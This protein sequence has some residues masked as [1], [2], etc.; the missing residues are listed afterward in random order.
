V[1]LQDK[2]ELVSS[3]ETNS[4]SLQNSDK[5]VNLPETFPTSEQNDSVPPQDNGEP[6]NPPET[7]PTSEQ[8]QS[9]L[10]DVSK[11]ELLDSQSSTQQ[12]KSNKPTEGTSVSK[13]TNPS[14]LDL[15]KQ[16]GFKL[17][18]VPQPGKNQENKVDQNNADGNSISQQIQKTRRLIENSS[19]SNGESESTDDRD[20]DW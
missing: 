18:K 17:K 6:V 8:N 11:K 3:S 12:K 15:I 1:S 5:P 13:E 14:H 2:D 7:F 19:S 16:G 4:K 20:K 10:E 9:L